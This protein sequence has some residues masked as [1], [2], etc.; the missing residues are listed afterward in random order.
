[1]L[2][3][4]FPVCPPSTIKF[5]LVKRGTGRCEKIDP[6]PTVGQIWPSMLGHYNELRKRL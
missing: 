1:V 3:R 4:H 2:R 6:I 5:A